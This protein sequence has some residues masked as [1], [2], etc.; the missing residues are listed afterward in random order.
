M[1]DKTDGRVADEGI[2][3][4][5]HEKESKRLEHCGVAGAHAGRGWCLGI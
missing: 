2:D 5:I 3:R 1:S 4:V